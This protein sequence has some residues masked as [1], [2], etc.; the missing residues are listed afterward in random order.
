MQIP[1]RPKAFYHF[2]MTGW[3]FSKIAQKCKL[4]FLEI[5]IHRG[6]VMA[7]MKVQSVDD[8]VRAAEK[9]DMRLNSTPPSV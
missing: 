9:I 7:K 2:V 3:F 8:L 4:Y 1:K 5:K 6:R